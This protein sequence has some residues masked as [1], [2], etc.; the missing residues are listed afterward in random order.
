M[1]SAGAGSP[2]SM[3]FLFLTAALIFGALP[4]AAQN[5]PAGAAVGS[6][7]FPRNPCVRGERQIVIGGIDLD[8]LRCQLAITKEALGTKDQALT[9]L[10][11]ELALSRSD[12]DAARKARADLDAY[13][14]ACGDKPGCTS[15]VDG[16]PAA[17][18]P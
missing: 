9:E 3:R 16:R 1:S 2:S 5:L 10:A 11:A 13:L 14:R 17:G 12:L 15:P 7:P 4:A 18:Q 6:A 8:L